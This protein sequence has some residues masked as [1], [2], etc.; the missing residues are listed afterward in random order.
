MGH[1]QKNTVGFSLTMSLIANV[2]CNL[3]H[4]MFTMN[5]P[6]TALIS[7]VQEADH[8]VSVSR[9]VQQSDP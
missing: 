4:L 3:L 5:S 1:Y 9:N 6:K 2:A 7:Y 8:F